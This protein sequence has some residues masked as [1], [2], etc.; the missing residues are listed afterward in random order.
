MS[1]PRTNILEPITHNNRKTVFRVQSDSRV[2]YSDMRLVDFGLSAVAGGTGQ[3]NFAYASGAYALIKNVRLY[4]G[5]T[6]LDQCLDADRIMGHHML[7]GTTMDKFD[8]DQKLVCSSLNIRELQV[9]LVNNQFQTALQPLAN[10]L[11]A[12]IKLDEMLLLLKS[13]TYFAGW[14]GDLRLE[15]EYN[16]DPTVVLAGDGVQGAMT[17]NRPSLVFEDEMD[18]QTTMDLIKEQSGRLP[19]VWNT[20]EREYISS[21]TSGLNAVRIRAF[22][23]KMVNHL[24]MSV[25]YAN[26]APNE[27]LGNGYSLEL[28]Q[29]VNFVVNGVRLMP[30][31]GMDSA[32]R[33]AASAADQSVLGLCVPTG[34]HD[35]TTIDIEAQNEFSLPLAQL[36]GGV[37]YSAYELN[38]VINRLDMEFSLAADYAEQNSA[39]IWASVMKF[40]VK[41]AA[42]GIVVGYQ[43]QSA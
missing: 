2:I 36:F 16:T 33:R 1:Q 17:V 24:I 32:A 11:L 41:D 22:D 18:E 35:L 31:A 15:I 43:A 9:D 34:C 38:T 21:L 30:L 40:L 19:V 14:A 20:Y 27:D 29:K 7:R 13:L 25:G 3:E 28:G 42:G 5:N 10:K 8:L 37:A 39:Y 23:N 12:R 26:G 4:S 6:L